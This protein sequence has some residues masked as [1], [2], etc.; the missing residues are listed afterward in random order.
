MAQKKIT[1]DPDNEFE[2]AI[3]EIVSM[4]R[5]KAEHYAS[6]HDPCGNFGEIAKA[7]DITPLQACHHL[8]AKHRNQAKRFVNEGLAAER[9]SYT[10]DAFLDGAVYGVLDLILY[11]R[12]VKS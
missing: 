10:D 9:T 3:I 8:G 11:R 12:Q 4:H 5:A 1:L 2:S 7:E 6:D